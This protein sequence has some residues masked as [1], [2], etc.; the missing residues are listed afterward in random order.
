MTGRR[1]AKPGFRI[2][3]GGPASPLDVHVYRDSRH[4]GWVVRSVH[5]TQDGAIRMAVRIARRLIRNRVSATI[6]ETRFLGHRRA[7]QV[8][9]QL[10]E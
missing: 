3:R 10:R 9:G 5:R 1:R 6:K 8:E 4:V 7:D 2:H